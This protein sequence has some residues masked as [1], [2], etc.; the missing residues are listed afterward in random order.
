[1]PQLQYHVVDHGQLIGI[2]DFSWD[3]HRHLGEFDG[4]IKYQKLLRPDETASD[5]V[6]REKR[7]EDAMRADLRGMT[8][9]TWSD[10]MPQNARQTMADLAH[11]LD[12]SYRLYVRGRTMIAS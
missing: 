8:R 11:A 6:F 3:D 1:M 5:C 4:K 9:F 7:R 12:R 2:A 10:V